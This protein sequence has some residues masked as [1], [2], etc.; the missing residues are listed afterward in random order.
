MGAAA[1]Q[2]FLGGDSPAAS[3]WCCSTRIAAKFTAVAQSPGPCVYSRRPLQP[4]L[5]TAA[6]INRSSSRG[7]TPIAFQDRT[8]CSMRGRTARSRGACGMC[9]ISWTYKMAVVPLQGGTLPCVSAMYL[10]TEAA[11]RKLSC[12]PINKKDT[13]EAGQLTGRGRLMAQP[14]LIQTTGG[15]LSLLRSQQ[16]GRMTWPPLE[17]K[18][19]QWLLSTQPCCS[20]SSAK[21]ARFGSVLPP[22]HHSG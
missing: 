18:M 16:Y 19:R 10:S 9:C 3:A 2:P 14:P 11:P 17:P 1:L 20:T 12:P 15:M 7:G 4:S 6:R 13:A 22:C 8:A 5:L 21:L